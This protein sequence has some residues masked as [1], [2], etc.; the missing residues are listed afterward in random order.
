MPK[1]RSATLDARGFTVTDK[2]AVAQFPG[3]ARLVMNGHDQ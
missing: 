3:P 1:A 2:G